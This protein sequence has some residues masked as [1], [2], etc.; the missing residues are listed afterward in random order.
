MKVKLNFRI[1][2]LKP[3]Q[4]QRSNNNGTVIEKTDGIVE[5]LCDD[6]STGVVYKVRL[7][8]GRLF[9]IHP[10]SYE[11]KGKRKVYAKD[12]KGKWFCY[13]RPIIADRIRFPKFYVPFKPGFAVKGSL[14]VYNN[15]LY[16]KITCCYNQN[17]ERQCIEASV[18][19]D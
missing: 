9:D 5:E 8:D 3:K 1:T 10:D 19:N 15:K 2:V 16:Y 17:D 6:S 11:T 13:D 18:I 12:N 4:K 14:V 7:S